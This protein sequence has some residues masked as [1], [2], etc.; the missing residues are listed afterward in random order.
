MRTLLLACLL[1]PFV[2]AAIA[3]TPTDRKAEIDR[4]KA[5]AD[6]KTRQIGELAQKGGLPTSDEAMALLQRM[7]DEL[8][9]IRE[10]LK[11]LEGEE[12]AAQPDRRFHWGGFAQFQYADSDRAGNANFDAFQFRR[13]RLVLDDAISPRFNARVSFDL[14]TGANTNNANLRDAIFAWDGSG[15]GHM[16]RDIFWA[17][18]FTPPVGYE[19]ERGELEREFPERSQFNGI[20]FA[21]ERTRGVE[22]R[23]TD[24]RW[25][26]R[27]GGFDALT[28]GDP[29][30]ANLA[31]GTGDRLAVAAAARYSLSKS[32]SVGVSG[33]AG[34]RPEYTAGGG[35]SPK[36]DRR[37]VYLDGRLGGLFDGRLT[38]LGEALFGHDRVPNAVGDPSREGND[39]TGYSLVGVWGLSGRD[40]LAFRWEGFDPDIDASGN[41]LHGLGIAYLRDF[42]PNLRFTVAHEVFVDETRATNFGQTRYGQTTLRLQVRF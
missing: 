9:E 5:A 27:A 11:R 3:Q 4:L 33:F 16:G 14:A 15:S 34:E 35:T 13:I 29:E 6:A 38:F 32:T 21:A 18:Q 42:T 8:K 25:L 41:A 30:Q 23:R 36:T 12:A 2:S 31:P 24:G 39:L 7:V 20:L 28:I 1:V 19:L 10:R 22:Y 37:F 26:L 40:R 17:G